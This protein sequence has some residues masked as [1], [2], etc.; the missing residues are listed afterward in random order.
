MKKLVIAGG[1]G[2]LGD[3]LIHYFGSKF[4]E[5][6]ILARSPHKNTNNITYVLWDAKTIGDWTQ[7]LEGADCVINLCGKSV[8][9]RYNEKNKALIFSS[10]LDSTAVL[11]K[12]I[13]NCKDAPKV[14][15]NAASATIYRYS[16]DKIMTEADGEVGEG[17]SVEVCKAWEKVFNEAQT[18]NTRKI[19]LRISMVMG[20]RAG[21]FPVLRKLTKR[22]LGG[23]MGS[24]D[25]FVS[26][27]HQEDFCRLVEWL[28][29][30]KNAAGP[31]NVAAPHPISNNEM[32]KIYRKVLGVPF[33]LPATEWILEIGAFFIKTE[34][35]LILK[36]RNVISDRAMK[37]GFAF[38]YKTMEECVKNLE[39]RFT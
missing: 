22:F 21:V 20:K 24:G 7:Y 8:D 30:N 18:P 11:G 39:E 15:M 26:W 29:N 6:I 2:F 16:K 13:A 4:D 34:T 5:Y 9:C 36:S 37:E 3:A 25:Q 28:I 33:G 23:K 32:M 10:R 31:Y 12:A 14:W 27:I 1:S 38:K 17:F 35:E 19:N